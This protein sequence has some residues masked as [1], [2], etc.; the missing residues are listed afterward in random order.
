MGA[1]SNITQEGFGPSGFHAYPSTLRIDGY[2]G[3]YGPG[4]LGHVVNTGTYIAHDA[5][6]GW[7]A[8]GGNMTVEG[9]SVRVRP[10][11]SSR[12]RVYIAPM[13]LWL[14]LDAGAFESVEILPGEVRVT[15][16][17]ATAH[18]STARMRIE[19]LAEGAGPGAMM[20]VG[21]GTPVP[22][23]AHAMERGAYLIPLSD[24]LTDVVLRAEG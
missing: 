3:D 5:E 7:L 8:F 24:A 20:G 19:R 1:I 17:P 18:T 15:L 9:E 14:T 6:F 21:E 12:S 10:L 23:Q 13:G 2:S 4:F 11:D 16:A 22:I